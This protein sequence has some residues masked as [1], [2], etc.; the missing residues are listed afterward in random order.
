MA[1]EKAVRGYPWDRTP[2][3]VVGSGETPKQTP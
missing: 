2:P 3:T 1:Y